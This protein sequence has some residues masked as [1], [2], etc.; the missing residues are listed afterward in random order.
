MATMIA[1]ASIII[2]CSAYETAM[3]DRAAPPLPNLTT[4]FHQLDPRLPH[5]FYRVPSLV[6]SLNGTLLAFV[7]GRFHRTDATPNILYLR[8]SFDDGKTWQPAQTVLQDPHNV[9]EYGAVPVV[10]PKT[11]AVHLVFSANNFG[12]RC[13]GCNARYALHACISPRA[14]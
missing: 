12:K 3:D 8:R 9:T 5:G 14:S 1:F 2:S 6:T 10:D 13:S 7:S 4:L 11:G